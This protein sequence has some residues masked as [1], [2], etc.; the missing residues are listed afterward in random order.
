MNIARNNTPG[1]EGTFWSR[2][3]R[4]IAASKVAARGEQPTEDAIER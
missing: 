3:Y 1:W 2:Y 4:N